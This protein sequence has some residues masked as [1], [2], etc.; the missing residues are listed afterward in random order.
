MGLVDI[1]LNSGNGDLVKQVSQKAGLDEESANELLKT[2]SSSMLGSIKGRATKSEHES[3]KLED[4]IKNS[5]YAN[6]IDSPS[7]HYND[8]RMVENGNDLLRHITGSKQH[9]REIAK[10]VS[11]KTGVSP[12]IIKALLPMLAPLIIGALSK[13]MSGGATSREIQIPQNDSGGLLGSLLD[14]DH[15]GSIID[16]VA[17]MAMKYILH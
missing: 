5:K 9:S 1:L 12:S 3:K 4:L 14:F 16:D 7:D 11:H 8:P 13:G 2:L 10:Q 17:G 6:M 15:D